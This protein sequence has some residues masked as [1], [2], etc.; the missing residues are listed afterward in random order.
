MN[1]TMEVTALK[2]R[3]GQVFMIGLPGTEL[4]VATKT[5]IKEFHIG[6]VILFARNIKDPVQLGQ[7][8]RDLQ[9]AALGYQQAPL[10]MAVDQEGGRVARLKEPFT[11]FPGNEALGES[12]RPEASTREYAQVTAREMK[13]VGLNMNMAP[14]VDVRRGEAEKHL[15]GRMFSDDPQMV[16]RLARIVIQVFQKNRVMA[17]AK[18]FPGLGPAQIDPHFDLPRITL[19]EVEM[20]EVNLWPF[21]ESIEE[22]VVAIMTSHAVYPG[23]DPDNPATLS[24]K[25]ITQLLREKLGYDGLVITDDLEM[26]AIARYRGVARGAA[27]AFLAGADILLVCENQDNFKKAYGELRDRILNKEIPWERFME[28]YERINKIK[29]KYLSDMTMIGEKSI[30]EYFYRKA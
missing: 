8:C 2:Q 22:G 28:S 1:S 26:G 11:I 24:H 21:R 5:L 30:E 14:V 16:S 4:D 17:V 23:L 7:L 3:I 12:E 18:H 27:E 25:V 13:M 9:S 10:F 15:S 6:G 19:D 29:K 20:E